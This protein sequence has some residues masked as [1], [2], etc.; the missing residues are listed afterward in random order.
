MV[1]ILVHHAVF[2]SNYGVW[3]AVAPSLLRF[4]WT[5]VDLFFVL[6]G[7]LVGGLL[8]KEIQRTSRLNLKRFLIR[9]AFKIWPAY[10]MFL[11][12]VW[13]KG[14]RHGQSCSELFQVLWPNF[15]HVQNYIRTPPGHT[16]SLAV[17][18]H[19]YVLLPVFLLILV[20][21][22]RFDQR[23]LRFIPWA[24]AGVAFFCLAARFISN[25]GRPF[26]PETHYFPTHL[27]LDGLLIGV[28]LSYGYH[29]HIK[30]VNRMRKK[31]VWLA[32]AGFLMLLP[33]FAIAGD[34]PFVFTVGY[35]I[36]A[37]AY[38][39]LI[40]AFVPAPGLPTVP[41]GMQ[42]AMMKGVA[43]VG[44]CSYSIYLWHQ[45]LGSLPA[46]YWLQALWLWLPREWQW[47][48]YMACYLGLAFLAGW[49]MSRCVE[50]PC[51]RIREWLVP[52]ER[53][54]IRFRTRTDPIAV[55]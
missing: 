39:L 24:A 32:V 27:R 43:A 54:D 2:Q 47:T 4:G 40:L 38:S 48:G 34:R 16:W 13:A 19:F 49:V 14:L 41:T 20:Q 44:T 9:R 25:I 52:V 53:K 45:D 33:F 23:C 46:A 1:L 8:I 11:A 10:F 21:R 50:I 12:F 55:I 37:I 7:F 51:L 31:K 5:G 28:A 26:V 3:S 42:G 29:C 36:L 17:E 15:L 22:A 30:W 6:S 18:E 35:T